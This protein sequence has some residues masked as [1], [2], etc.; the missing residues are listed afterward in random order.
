MKRAAPQDAAKRA[1]RRLKRTDFQRGDVFALGCCLYHV[2]SGGRHPF[3]DYPCEYEMR[4]M[5]GAQLRRE[6]VLEVPPS[7]RW[8]EKRWRTL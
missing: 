4:I 8:P 2:L 6:P 5:Q 1:K 7:R 3:G